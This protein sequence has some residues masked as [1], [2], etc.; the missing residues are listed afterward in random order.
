MKKLLFLFVCYSFGG[1]L[2]AQ[3]PTIVDTIPANK[4]V[5]IEEFTGAC[6]QYC[7]DGHKVVSE[8]MKN[9]PGRVYGI[10]IHAGGYTQGSGCESRF[11]SP[12][13]T[14][15]HNY[16]SPTA[17]PIAKVA[18]V[19][20][21]TST[22]AEWT[23]RT[24]TRLGESS[25]LNVAAEGTIDWDTRKLTVL[26]EVYYTGT[27]ASEK[28][29]LTVAL[30]QNN[31]VGNQSG[32][33][34]NPSQ[35][36]VDGK[37][38][39]MHM[40][41]DIISPIW[42]DTIE[43]TTQGS[44][45]TK[46]YEYDIPDEINTVDVLLQDI[47]IIA[48]VA[49]TKE[50]IIS[51]TK[52]ELTDLNRPEIDAINAEFLAINRYIYVNDC[53]NPSV[54]RFDIKNK[55]AD[56][57]TSIKY[58]IKNGEQVLLQDLVWNRRQIASGTKDTLIVRN[59]PCPN[60][61]AQTISVEIIE[62]NDSSFN[63]VSEPLKILKNAVEDAQGDMTLK[64]VTD[65]YASST[66]YQ[67]YNP[68]GTVIS[69]NIVGGYPSWTDLVTNGTTERLIP[70]HV[71]TGCFLIAVSDMKGAGINKGNGAGYIELL[72]SN[73]VRLFYNDGKFGSSLYIY[74]NVATP[75]DISDNAAAQN[76]IIVFPNPANDQITILSENIPVKKV[77][78]YNIQGQ[79]IQSEL[80]NENTM[81]ISHLAAG[82]YSLRII[83]E[84]G[85][86]V[87]NIIKQ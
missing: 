11:T 52:A 15:I 20:T 21:L 59:I 42:G 16:F 83:T 71:G 12:D 61:T 47:E 66:Y 48:F 80:S 78:M 82:M 8:L 10:N 44:F 26:V 23:A 35:Q 46:T 34:Y 79:L 81:N 77:E 68:S 85:V 4:N 29:Y 30:L 75:S 39:H 63:T 32:G 27:T 50:T 28:N 14:T 25:Y 84:K 38:I 19:G 37:Y 57:I 49:E 13:G 31:I 62:I 45:F 65:R 67:I 24:N 6:C 51:G 64:I 1:A 40:L 17:Y 54:I 41:R 7:P 60:N 73:N 18:R 76:N 70:L 2:I 53:N 74:V 56:A 9:N 5:I 86:I 87:K 43:T 22:R 36:L 72:D 33:Q 3:T 55:G 58:N 69:T